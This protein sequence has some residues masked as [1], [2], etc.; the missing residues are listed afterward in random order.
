MD[1]SKILGLFSFELISK[2][3]PKLSGDCLK[4]QA[5]KEKRDFH[6]HDYWL[7]W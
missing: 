6:N 5:E 4:K 7:K 2:P 3:K 1:F